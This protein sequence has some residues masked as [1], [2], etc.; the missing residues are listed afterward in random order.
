MLAGTRDTSTSCTQLALPQGHGESFVL[1]Q[2][3]RLGPPFPESHCISRAWLP[4]PA[5]WS[6]SE[7]SPHLRL[8]G[9][10]GWDL[11]PTSSIQSWS[12]ACWWGKDGGLEIDP[13][14]VCM[15]NCF[16]HVQ[17]FATLWTVSC[18]APLSK[19]FSRQEHWSEFLCVPP[20]DL[21]DPGIKASCLTS[22]ALLGGFFPTS[23]TWEAQIQ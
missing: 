4:C 14:C 10:R 1:I 23:A 17:L 13:K 18:Q 3:Q 6:H 15:L 16:S 22:P 9:S 2:S 12:P 19:G 8:L 5:L 7:M 11:G 20:G 21:P